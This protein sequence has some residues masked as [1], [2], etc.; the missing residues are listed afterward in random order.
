MELYKLFYYDLAFKTALTQS[1]Q[2][3]VDN[4]YIAYDG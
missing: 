4:N 1:L 3:M 2:Q